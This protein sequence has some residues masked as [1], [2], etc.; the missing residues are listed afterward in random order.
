MSIAEKIESS[1]LSF[2]ARD[3]QTSRCY[4]TS[5]RETDCDITLKMP[6]DLVE[7]LQYKADAMG[8]YFDELILQILAKRLDQSQE[9]IDME[10]AWQTRE[11]LGIPHEISREELEEDRVAS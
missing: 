4:R 11:E 5:V 3:E 6:V 9:Q 10:R 7:D 1:V 2:Y 8:V